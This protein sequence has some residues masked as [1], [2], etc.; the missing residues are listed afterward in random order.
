MS[1]DLA[2]VSPTTG[3]EECMRLITRRRIRHLPVLR[4]GQL[5]GLV[6]IGDVV[7]YRAQ[8]GEHQVQELTAYIQGRYV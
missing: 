1:T 6:S 2:C 5:V 3:V 7:R 8:Q 4:N